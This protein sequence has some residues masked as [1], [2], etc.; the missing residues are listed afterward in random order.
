MPAPTTGSGPEAIQF[1][2]RGDTSQYRFRGTAKQDIRQTGANHRRR[3]P[4]RRKPRRKRGVGPAPVT[5]H[6]TTLDRPR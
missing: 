3:D 4:I 6:V 5:A 1:A 2:T